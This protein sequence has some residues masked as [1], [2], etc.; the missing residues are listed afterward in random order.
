MILKYEQKNRTL[1]ERGGF[2]LK[3]L[4]V[5]GILIFFFSRYFFYSDTA[6]GCRIFLEP[7]IFEWNNVTLYKKDFPFEIV[8]YRISFEKNVTEEK[9]FLKLTRFITVT[10]RENVAE[11]QTVKV[12]TSMKDRLLSTTH[13]KAEVIREEGKH[14]YLWQVRLNPGEYATLTIIENYRFVTGVLV[15][16][17]I[18]LLIVYVAKDPISIVKQSDD[19]KTFEEGILEVKVVLAIK[20]HTN[21]TFSHVEILDKVPNIAAIKKGETHTLKPTKYMQAKDGTILKWEIGTMEPYEERLL[22]YVMKSKLSILGDFRM[23]PALVKFKDTDGTHG[24]VRSNEMDIS[25]RRFVASPRQSS[26]DK[27]SGNFK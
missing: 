3:T 17:G 16:L 19:V 11:Q 1:A 23:P 14:Y 7:G 21:R 20:N 6:N 15:I 12:E 8:A 18:F 25:S 22:M 2:F 10:N 5:V 4:V 13:P 27:E 26:G 24:S 9:K